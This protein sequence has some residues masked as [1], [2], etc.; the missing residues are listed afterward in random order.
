MHETKLIIFESKIIVQANGIPLLYGM[1]FEPGKLFLR[2]E[3][4]NVN[5]LNL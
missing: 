5:L 2:I 1:K 3:F 4:F